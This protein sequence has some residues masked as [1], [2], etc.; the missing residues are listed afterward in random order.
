MA[1]VTAEWCF[2]NAEARPIEVTLTFPVPLHAALVGLSARI[3]EGPTR[4]PSVAAGPPC[5][6]RRCC[7]ASI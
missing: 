2:G 4:M 7:A 1:L 6:M 5:C 3:G